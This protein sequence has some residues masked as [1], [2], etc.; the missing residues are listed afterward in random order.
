MLS[1]LL[2]KYSSLHE[3]DSIVRAMWSTS[4]QHISSC[5]FLVISDYN[6]EEGLSPKRLLIFSFLTLKRVLQI[7]LL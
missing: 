1:M 7:S 6:T 4:D 5:D 3:G 2:G